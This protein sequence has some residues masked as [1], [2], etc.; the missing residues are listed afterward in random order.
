MPTLFE[1]IKEDEEL[2]QLPGKIKQTAKEIGTGVLKGAADLAGLPGDAV[3]LGRKIVGSKELPVG[4]AKIREATGLG[5]EDTAVETAAGLFGPGLPGKAGT[6]MLAAAGILRPKL[7]YHGTRG[8]FAE[9]AKGLIPLSPS[10][11]VAQMYASGGGGNRKKAST[12]LFVDEEKGIAYQI[13]PKSD[14]TQVEVLTGKDKGKKLDWESSKQVYEDYG[15]DT[16]YLTSVATG[17]NI[18]QYAV[19]T[20]KTL[21]LRHKGYDR[22]GKPINEGTAVLAQLDPKGNAWVE[23]IIDKA[24]GGDFDWSNTKYPAAQAAWRDIVIPQL[25][26]KGYDSIEYWDDMHDTLAV[27]SN[28]NLKKVSDVRLPTQD[29]TRQDQ[30]IENLM[31]AYKDVGLT[32]K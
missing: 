14:G 27:F 17:A 15:I 18:R 24:K 23:G 6:G 3:N 8:D 30:A 25:E 32:F 5:T 31:K 12:A 7:Y 10:P 19:D 22:N 2:Q 20:N 16:D 11:E 13:V 1:L 28:K 21:N 4:S 29:K 9:H 26:A